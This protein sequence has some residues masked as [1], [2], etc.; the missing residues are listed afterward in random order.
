MSSGVQHWGTFRSH[1]RPRRRPYVINN[2]G[3]YIEKVNMLCVQMRNDA[4][5]RNSLHTAAQYCF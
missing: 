2:K 5:D 3:V 1:E 4:Y